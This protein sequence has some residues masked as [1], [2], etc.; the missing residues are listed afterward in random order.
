MNAADPD[1][2]SI[3]WAIVAY[4]ITTIFT[5]DFGRTSLILQDK[6][7]TAARGKQNCSP[8]LQF[9][10]KFREPASVRNG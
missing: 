3:L 6:K 8:G 9:R 10:C 5:H 1:G 4:K 2:G 7:R